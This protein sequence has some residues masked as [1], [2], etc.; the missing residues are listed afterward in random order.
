M[1]Y[2]RLYFEIVPLAAVSILAAFRCIVLLFFPPTKIRPKIEIF[3]IVSVLVLLISSG[4]FIKYL[5]ASKVLLTGYKSVGFSGYPDLVKSILRS[6][7]ID[8]RIFAI[9][10]FYVIYLVLG[11]VRPAYFLLRNKFRLIRDVN[12]LIKLVILVA[13]LPFAILPLLIYAFWYRRRFETHDELLEGSEYISDYDYGIMIIRMKL[14]LSW[15]KWAFP[16]R[17]FRREEKI[18]IH[19]DLKVK[20]SILDITNLILG[21]P[22]SGKTN[23]TFN[24]FMMPVI[25]SGERIIIYDY[26]GDFT[27]AL[28]GRDDAVMISPFDKRSARWAIGKDVT[29]TQLFLE[30]MWA[31]VA[32]SNSISK[33][34]FFDTSFVDIAAG[35]YRSLEDK[36][37]Q[38]WT[39]SDLYERLH[40]LD[41]VSS[42]IE[43]FRS[44]ASMFLKGD[45][46]TDQTAGVWGT[47]RE[48]MMNF[49]ALARCWKDDGLEDFSLTEFL[50]DSYAGSKKILLIRVSPDFPRLS[51]DFLSSIF[52]LMIRFMSAL[53]DAVGERHISFEIDELQTL[54]RIPGILEAPRVI[55]SKGL[56]LGL[57]T[58]DFAKTKI[59]YRDEGGIEGLSNS[60]GLKLIG[61][62][63]GEEVRRE[64]LKML[65]TS[66]IKRY[67][68]APRSE[69]DDLRRYSSQILDSTPLVSG[70]FSLKKPDL[71]TPAEFF[72]QFSNWPIIRLKFPIRPMPKLYPSL[73]KAEWLSDDDL[74]H[75]RSTRE[76]QDDEKKK[77]I[78]KSLKKAKF[79]RKT[80][81]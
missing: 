39:F 46:S 25:N 28:G 32:T 11:T 73:V 79:S 35:V 60:I 27:E 12:G 75:E 64:A 21:S 42:D 48:K 80:E 45:D 26:K 15:L 18:K 57:R 68:L 23:V 49:E 58:Q 3:I 63:E 2:W 56:H 24:H 40:N 14:F 71:Q 20:R 81:E 55:R 72:V 4:F 10:Q 30:M 74:R 47:I 76:T 51:Q 22:G 13:F 66:R 9:F 19:P 29:D 33:K 43:E 52:Q 53:P 62:C 17:L 8:L 78:S 69:K 7:E 44:E 67:S 31:V 1:D 34:S 6:P 65:S 54:G 5:A 50:S 37:G 70:S 77:S 59:D 36:K 41:E 61:R 16:T 38:A